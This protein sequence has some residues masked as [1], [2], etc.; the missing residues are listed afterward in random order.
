MLHQLSLN[1]MDA[2]RAG[3]R[4]D[5]MGLLT[6]ES[7]ASGTEEADSDPPEVQEDYWD[8][9]SAGATSSGFRY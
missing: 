8:A 5:P 2:L 4:Y 9:A 6:P 7:Q 1:S 3:R